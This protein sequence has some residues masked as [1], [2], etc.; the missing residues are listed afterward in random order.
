[1]RRV[2]LC[3][4]ILAAEFGVLEAGLR[5]HGGSDASP[6]FQSLFMQDP[7][8]GHRLR[9][10]A[11]ALYTTV[12]FSTDLAINAQGVRD[13]Q[14]IGP[15]APDERR[16]VVLG[17]SLVFSVQV[18]LVET[19]CKRLEARLNAAN[20]G[21]RWRVINAGVQGYGPVQ[22][23]FFFDRVAAA[24]EADIV[25]T[26]AYVANDAIEAHD[27]E[28]WL[29]AG[30]PVRANEGAVGRL[31]Q[32]V[33]SSIVLQLVRLR[34]TQLRG[35]FVTPAPE[36]PLSTYLATPPQEVLNGLAVSRQAFARIA[37]RA[38]GAGAR[39]ALVLMPARFQTNDDDYGRLAET[40]RQ[41]GGELVRH[42]ATD[43]FR[44]ALA[45]LGLPTL[46]LLPALERQPDRTGL[47]FQRNAHLTPRGHDVVAGALF[48]FLETSGLVA[49]A[50]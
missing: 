8:V 15:K 30:Q 14:P 24:F 16:I 31:R 29:E 48:D 11:R 2:F 17:D 25:L 19:F 37:D 9:P 5:I 1:M 12:E 20:D 10:N 13:D 46:D 42:A 35:R 40:V 50:R 26:V 7:A 39:P 18:P 45:P 36:R 47:F 3:L 32:V 41:S 23:W 33:R 22:E 34:W 4:V 44:A 28:R 6:A 49:S 43:R 27:T 38:R 21:R